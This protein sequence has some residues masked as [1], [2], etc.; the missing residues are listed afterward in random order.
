MAR[1]INPSDYC[2]AIC[3][4]TGKQCQNLRVDQWDTSLDPGLQSD[5]VPAVHDF[6]VVHGRYRSKEEIWSRL[7]KGFQL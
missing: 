5:Y 6:C 4:T 2:Q 3:S 1:E 7:R